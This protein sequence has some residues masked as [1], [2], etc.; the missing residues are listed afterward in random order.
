MLY[1][2]LIVLCA[3]I[4]IFVVSFLLQ[5]WCLKRMRVAHDAEQFSQL[6]TFSIGFILMLIVFGFS[7]AVTSVLLH[8]II[9]G[10]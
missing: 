2:Q 1:R 8:V 7:A 10:A 3:V 6:F 4:A 5:L 9:F